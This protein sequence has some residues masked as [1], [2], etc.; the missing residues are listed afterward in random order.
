MG[1]H[2]RG[3]DGGSGVGVNGGVLQGLSG[4][5]VQWNGSGS[6]IDWVGVPWSP[7]QTRGGECNI[8]HF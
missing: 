6:P 4:V 1:T 8:Q 2:D 7:T 3:L 5:G